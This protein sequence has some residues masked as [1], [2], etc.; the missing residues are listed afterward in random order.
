MQNVWES[1]KEVSVDVMRPLGF[2]KP[3]ISKKAEE[4][5]RVFIEILKLLRNLI[6][7]FWGWM[8]KHVCL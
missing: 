5:F 6:T 2:A 1:G 3:L 4:L 7:T 8:G